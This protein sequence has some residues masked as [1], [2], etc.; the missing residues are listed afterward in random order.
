MAACVNH[1]WVETDATCANCARA[2]CESCLVEFM[3][4]RYC[5]PCR[6]LKLAD[7]QRPAGLSGESG[8]LAGTGVV[9]IGGWLSRGW[10]IIQA[11]LPLFAL[12][13]L[14]TSILSLFSC[15]LVYGSMISG[16]FILCFSRMLH[17]RADFQQLWRGFQRFGNALAVV[18]IVVLV[19]VVIE[20]SISFAVGIPV[21]FAT[22]SGRTGS[23]LQDAG[24]GAAGLVN[25]LVSFLLLS[26]TFF[27][28]PLVAARNA[29]P[30]EA[31]RASWAIFTRNPGGFL[32]TAFVFEV[33][34]RLGVVL[35]CV[36]VFITIPWTLAA[37]A[38]AYVDYFGL[39]GHEEL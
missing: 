3:G 8:R 18:L 11:D 16:I 32:L 15:G 30:V 2:F 28:L 5:G 6:D 9:E 17:G 39:T 34:R 36:G 29:T 38:Q 26:A 13:A 31:F 33:L 37:Q 27:A 24:N 7:M 23:W 14:L 25:T 1:P 35:C 21:G 4:G 19:E 22:R 12:A 10:Q 20:L